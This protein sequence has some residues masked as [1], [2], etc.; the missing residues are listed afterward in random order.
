MYMLMETLWWDYAN[1]VDD[2]DEYKHLR[3]YPIA[4]P[5]TPI[6]G[7]SWITKNSDNSDESEWEVLEV[8]DC[9][10][11]KRFGIQYKATFVGNWDEWNSNPPWQLWTDFNHAED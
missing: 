11:T 4:C 9:R 1:E 7:R 10:K 8:V 3:D 2:S 6:P 5:A